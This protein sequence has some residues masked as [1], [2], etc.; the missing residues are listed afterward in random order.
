MSS[1]DLATLYITVLAEYC[2]KIFKE[3]THTEVISIKIDRDEQPKEIYA[4]AKIISYK[5]IRFCM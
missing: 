2:N 1:R 4:L 5:V 3:M